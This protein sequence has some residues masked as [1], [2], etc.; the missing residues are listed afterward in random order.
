M[1]LDPQAIR[2]WGQASKALIDLFRTVLPSIPSGEKR[3]EYET[4]LRVAEEAQ[5]RADAVLAQQLGYLMCR[6][7]FP[8]NPMLWRQAEQVYECAAGCGHR[9]DPPSD[10]PRFPKYGTM[11]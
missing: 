4:Q 7:T 2:D 5:R 6:C 10:G 8:P 9:T 3:A 11:A 1:D